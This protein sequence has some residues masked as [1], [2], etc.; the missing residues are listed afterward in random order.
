[1]RI[2]AVEMTPLVDRYTDDELEQMTWREL[3]ELSQ[4]SSDTLWYRVKR[5][6]MTRRQALTHEPPKYHSEMSRIAALHNISYDTL[7]TRRRRYPGVPLE[8]L[9]KR[10]VLT[11]RD[12]V[13]PG[14]RAMNG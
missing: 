12:R 14:L 7:A 3:G 1:M 5:E 8:E 4:Y 2:S 10:P 13:M 11:G 6:G 9:A